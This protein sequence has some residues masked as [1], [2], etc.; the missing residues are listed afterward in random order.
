MSNVSTR[1]W[2]GA[3]PPID[4]DLPDFDLLVL[5]AQEFQPQI[6]AFHGPILRCP[7]PDAALD[8]HQ[9]TQAVL[10]AK[11]AGDAL[12]TGQR[13]LVTCWAGMNR[14]VLV[15]SMALA[16]VTRMTADQ[17]IE[18]MRRRRHPQALYNESFQGVL[19]RLV[20]R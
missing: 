19:R 4:R 17:I 13:V 14:S 1:L 15:A 10:T 20:R 12:A 3:H 11:R 18:L 9:I 5:C 16:R 8:I 7:L 2:V 6:L